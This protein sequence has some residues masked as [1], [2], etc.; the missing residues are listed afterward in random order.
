MALW[1]PNSIN[2]LQL[3]SSLSGYWF[4]QESMSCSPADGGPKC[5]SLQSHN[6]FCPFSLG[7]KDNKYS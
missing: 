1:L 2:Y 4:H 5:T 6:R 3:P 7:R